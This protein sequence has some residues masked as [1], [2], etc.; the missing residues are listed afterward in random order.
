MTIS[1]DSIIG[2]LPD[3]PPYKSN[4]VGQ[5]LCETHYPFGCQ[6][7][8]KKHYYWL[9]ENDEEVIMLEGD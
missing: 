8:C 4:K 3:C 7:D 9:I 1:L 2:K 5:A 6:N